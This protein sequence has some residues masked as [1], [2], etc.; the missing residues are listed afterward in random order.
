MRV[1]V[2][3][4]MLPTA[5]HP[6][7]GI[8]VREQIDDL[9]DLGVDV[10]VLFVNG[11]ESRLEYVRGIRR[12]RRTVRDGEVDL[13][14]AHYG[15]TGAI[16]LVQR[17]APV[18][19]TFH[20]SDAN[21]EIPWQRAVSRLV[22]RS[23]TPIFVSRSL[24]AGLGHERAA[25]IPAAVDLEAFRPLDRLEARRA[26]GWPEAG[27]V[28]LLPGSRSDPVK[29]APLFDA[30]LD[31]ARRTLP[32]L[33]GASL[34]GLPRE[35]VALTM[36]AVDVTVMT[37]R[38]EGSPVAVKESLACL[39][40]VVSVRVGDLEEL[41]AGLPGCAIVPRD[42]SRIGEALV[43]A[44]D[45]GRPSELREGVARFSRPVIAQQV[46]DL[47]RDVLAREARRAP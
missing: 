41:L 43:A 27:T 19:T 23:S 44:V 8:F 45:A 40:P 36:N 31:H 12:L 24:A 33:R 13:V 35:Q 15:L 2:V 37:S 39:T 38:S 9:R 25:V 20:G 28:A 11:L 3:T 32:D 7:Y 30:A 34:E 21:G 1:L 16:A 14:H 4:N 29:G 6:W 46:V 17:R 10:S 22:A 18:V 42:S 47:Y 5:R 26:L